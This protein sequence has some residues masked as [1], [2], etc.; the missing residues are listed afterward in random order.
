MLDP[1]ARAT[2]APGAAGVC[3]WR[4]IFHHRHYA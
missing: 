1:R 2:A 3:R 4:S